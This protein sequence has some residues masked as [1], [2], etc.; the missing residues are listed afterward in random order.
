MSQTHTIGKHRT[1]IATI[2]TQTHVRYWSTDVVTFDPLWITLNT[3]GYFT[4]TTKLRMNQA[5]SQFK[6]G[7]RV[8]QR[9]YQWY[10]DLPNGSTIKMD[11]NKLTFNRRTKEVIA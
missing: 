6:L 2:G 1:D 9:D 8:Y 3:D 4:T 10:V 7:F 11:K 5:S